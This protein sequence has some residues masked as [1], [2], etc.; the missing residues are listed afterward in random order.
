L[1][2]YHG[3][4]ITPRAKLHELA[5]KHFCVPFSD[6]R[7]AETCVKIGQ[8][9]MFDN[10]AFSAYTRGETYDSEAFCDWVM[11]YLKPPHWAVIPDVIGG[12]EK[13]NMALA[14]ACTI[15]P[16]LC[17]PVWHLNESLEQL[18]EL[19][20]QWPGVCFGSAGEYWNVGTAAWA[21]RTNEAFNFLL[22]EFGENDMPWVHMLRG[23]NQSGRDWPFA[24][25]DSCNVALHHSEKKCIRA[26]ADRIDSVQCPLTWKPKPI[27]TEISFS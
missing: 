2:H 10:G 22:A 16:K 15:S 23:L 21:N 3:T 14:E 25:A 9:V 4:P 12:S 5:G 18:R 17:K 8:S 11:Q 19:A 20:R 13:Q 1:I 7:D 24:S 26:F 6:G 27:Q